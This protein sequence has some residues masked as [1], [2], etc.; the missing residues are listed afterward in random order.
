MDNA[1][2]IVIVKQI[3]KLVVTMDA[4]GF[5]TKLMASDEELSKILPKKM[6]DRIINLANDTHIMLQ[7]IEKTNKYRE[8]IKMLC[9]TKE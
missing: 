3:R 1:D 7:K 2:I 4:I 6:L 5:P 8:A 9:K